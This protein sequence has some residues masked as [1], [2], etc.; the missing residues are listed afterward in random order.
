MEV[1][2]G[3]VIVATI[4]QAAIEAV[5]G[6][7]SKWD[8][9]AVG[10]GVILCPLAGIDAFTIMG[11]PLVVPGVTWMG[12]YIGATLTGVIAG[13]G[14]NFVYDLWAKMKIQK[15]PKPPDENNQ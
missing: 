11:V 15:D 3:L 1:I 13:R 9:M 4:I 7:L 12:F 6:A 5:K 10:L 8:W 2:M 14:A